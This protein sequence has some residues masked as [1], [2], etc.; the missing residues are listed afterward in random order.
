MLRRALLACTLL[1]AFAPSPAWSADATWP[2]ALDKYLFG[3]GACDPGIK[4]EA[5][6]SSKDPLVRS[7]NQ[8]SANEACQLLRLKKPLLDSP[9]DLC[10]GVTPLTFAKC[11]SAILDRL[12]KRSPPST[13]GHML[14]GSVAAMYA[15]RMKT[16]GNQELASG[17]LFDT[18]IATLK[19]VGQHTP[20]TALP[21]DVNAK[22]DA[23]RERIAL[24]DRLDNILTREFVESTLSKLTRMPPPL[25]R[26][27]ASQ[28]APPRGQEILS[29]VKR[30]HFPDPT[31]KPDLDRLK[32]DLAKHPE[33]PHP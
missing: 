8:A 6:R 3:E 21:R 32:R 33:I 30:W 14:L 15:L 24:L 18:M 9:G 25:D 29:L 22:T 26:S 4:R 5:E 2:V 28:G 31:F 23:D 27:V 1:A 12:A 16:Q 11:Y 10:P 20:V 19:S 7:V 17:I 13:S